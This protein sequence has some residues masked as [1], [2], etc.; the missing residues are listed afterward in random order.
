LIEIKRLF[1]LVCADS[2][3]S[4]NVPLKL[5]SPFP[6]GFAENILGNYI[7]VKLIR[8]QCRLYGC[9]FPWV[10]FRHDVH[11]G[12]KRL[13]VVF[14]GFLHSDISHGEEVIQA[15]V[16]AFLSLGLILTGVVN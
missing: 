15:G 5:L 8:L 14:N 6:E 9:C 12:K 10:L 13:D 11:V 2:I 1:L 3:F 7:Q 16:S 4:V